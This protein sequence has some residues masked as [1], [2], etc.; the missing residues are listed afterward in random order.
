MSQTTQEIKPQTIWVLMSQLREDTKKEDVER[1]TQS[2][3]KLVD[4]WQSQGKFM[5]SGP[6]SDNKT[7]MAIFETTDEDAHKFYDEYSKI[8][9]NI[10][11]YH[12]Y[13]WESIP[14]L[15]IL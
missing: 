3:I 2:I 8:C 14:F 6:L 12:M 4:E 1:I 11:E 15:S 7:G 5:W 10:L 9:S 13:Q